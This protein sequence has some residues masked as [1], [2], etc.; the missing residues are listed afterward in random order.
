MEIHWK[1]IVCAARRYA[2]YGWDIMKMDQRR[3][4]LT[5]GFLVVLLAAVLFPLSTLL[6][7]N[8]E[9]DVLTGELTEVFERQA[10]LG[11]AGGGTDVQMAVDI[12]EIWALE[13]VRTE[14][15]DSLVS[16]MKNGDAPLGYDAD[17]QTFYCTLGE[18]RTEDWPPVALSAWGDE[19]LRV[20]FVDDY[21]YD[22][23]SDAIREGYRYELMAYTDTEYAYFGLVFTALPIV[24][25][26]P[27]CHF[28]DIGY[29][30]D[31][32]TLVSISS[33]DFET[34]QG[35]ALVHQRGG[36][37]YR[38]IDK[39]SY[40]LEF[41]E[42]E[43]YEGDSKRAVS[44]L[45]MPADTD[46]LLIASPVD[47]TAIRNQLSWEMW[48]DWNAGGDLGINVLESR[49]V[50]LFVEDEYLGLYQLMQ[51]IDVENELVRMG[52]DLDTDM[53]GRK[54]QVSNLGDRPIM[55]MGESEPWIAELRYAPAGMSEDEAFDLMKRYA[56]L[57]E[58]EAKTDNI[59]SDE[60]FEREVLAHF[61]IRSL[62]NYFLFVQA[63]SFGMDNVNNNV[64]IWTLFD[65]DGG[66]KHYLS[67]WDMDAGFMKLRT[68][69]DG[70]DEDEINMWMHL[71]NR[72]LSLD[73]GNSRQIAWEIWQ[74]KRTTILEES[75]LYQRLEDMKNRIDASG[76]YLRETEQWRGGAKE[77]DI[78]EM[79]AVACEHQNTVELNLRTLWP[80]EGLVY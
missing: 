33:A 32:G 26:D 39:N 59:L 44:A 80:P 19:N 41:H 28:M 3:K 51:R 13:D 29:D 55:Q 24:S 48:K 9:K 14:S 36:R 47:R 67:P 34:V 43:A 57:E 17:S 77:L 64:Y 20:I 4:I 63:M 12:E 56:L 25:L 53:V 69:P 58:L 70:N 50:E 79:Q 65:D 42:L 40:R 75:A 10:A 30:E 71:P 73:I 31:V 61:D 7:Q 49:M 38:G 60:A 66:Y 68:N 6:S 62:M 1:Y 21:A 16:M 78:E 52:G 37:F 74:E 23:C 15:E 5:T 8:V 11:G 45:G 22:F 2:I 35:V 27:D 18:G 54:I 76:A 46:W 72:V